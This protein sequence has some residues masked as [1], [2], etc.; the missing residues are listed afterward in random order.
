MATRRWIAGV[1]AIGLS[2]IASF[3][4]TSAPA[5]QTTQIATSQPTSRPDVAP[6]LT[7]LV[8]VKDSEMAIVR[9][10]YESDRRNLTQFYDVASSPTRMKRL[11]RFDS[12][13][14]KA[15]EGINESGLSG[16]G[17]IE[18][19]KLIETVEKGL[20][21]LAQQEQVQGDIA[22]LVPFAPQ[23]T[24]LEESWRRMEQVDGKKSAEVM[25]KAVRQM[26]E[27]RKKLSAKNTGSDDAGGV[28][29][30]KPMASNAAQTVEGLRGNMRTWF[31]F[32]NGVDPLFTW[33]AK[34]PYSELDKAMGEYDKALKDAGK[35]AAEASEE[36]ATVRPYEACPGEASDVPDLN[37]LIAF[38]RS[39]MRAVFDKYRPTRR[40]NHKAEFYKSWLDELEKID[41]DRLSRDGQVDYLLLKNS[42]THDLNRVKLPKEK[43]TAPKDSSGIRGTPIGRAA[44]MNDLAGEMIPYTPEELIHIAEK[45]FAWCDAEMLK[46]S[47]EMG[48]G[49]EW[50]K[51]LEKTKED[52]VEPG[53]Q[54]LLI[55]DLIRDSVEWV[56]S[57][58]MLTVPGIEVETLR[59]TM[60]SPQ[61]QLTSPFFLGGAF[62]QISA[63]TD[64]MP[65]D[66]RI[67]SMRGN[68]VAFSRATVHHELIPG[69]NSQSFAQAR[70]R[71]YRNLFPTPFWTEGWALYW[72]MR[73][74]DGGF[75]RT[76]EERIGFLFWRMHRCARIVFSLKFHLGEWSPQQC[77]DYLV[78][79][80]GH[81]RDN[82]AAEV[83]RSFAGNYGPLYQA[84]YMLGALQIRSMHK[85]LVESGKMS[86]REFHDGFLRQNAM[87]VA[88]VR[89]VLSGE[90][91]TKEGLPE[92]RFYGEHP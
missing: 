85:E 15:L 82:A 87:P 42:L 20:K 62:I 64:T 46:A 34:E 88:M 14:L 35:N 9:L 53:K 2:T 5:T 4:Q 60:L 61:Q 36:S 57:R 43:V 26:A 77:V 89:A 52:H 24:A 47:R 78:D 54:V 92:W 91:L 28:Q 50:K 58:G 55:R 40:G 3:G 8:G 75:A 68:N 67:Q 7:G 37:E 41:F 12:A 71:A 45:E 86:D 81:E 79:R 33:W 84:G 6:D 49:D 73:L 44:M 83:R 80:V 10:R 32:Y 72:E 90:K 39:D 1:A 13:W 66:A 31:G 17:A 30:T 70:Y 29:L 25:D 27:L 65:Y 18:R 59:A 69:H 21:E 38:P 11:R 63:P 48:F 56:S 74:Y 51:A 23:L 16:D 22:A 76:P 19:R